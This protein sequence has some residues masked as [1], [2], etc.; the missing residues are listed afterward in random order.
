MVAAVLL[1]LVLSTFIVAAYIGATLFVI[2]SPTETSAEHILA[3][4][5]LP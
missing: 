1:L 3:H 5:A 2:N 4:W